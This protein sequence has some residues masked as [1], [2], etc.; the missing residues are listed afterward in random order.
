MVVMIGA[1]HLVEFI[2]IHIKKDTHY[3][4]TNKFQY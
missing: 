2:D 4:Q 1:V 3:G